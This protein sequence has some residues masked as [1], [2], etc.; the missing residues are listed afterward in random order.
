[1]TLDVREGWTCQSLPRSIKSARSA[2]PCT[3]RSTST[4]CAGTYEYGTKIP[5]KHLDLAFFLPGFFLEK[6]QRAM[7]Y[8]SQLHPFF[9]RSFNTFFKCTHFRADCFGT[10]IFYGCME[11]LLVKDDIKSEV[12][13]YLE[14]AH[15]GYYDLLNKKK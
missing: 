8:F 15:S 12:A 1:M 4:S 11:A 14:N 7:I 3:R 2:T 6:G 5:I 10:K 9:D 13:G